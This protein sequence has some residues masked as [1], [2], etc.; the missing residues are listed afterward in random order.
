MEPDGQRYEDVGG[1]TRDL[2]IDIAREWRGGRVLLVAHSA[3]RWALAHL[4][5][6]VP[7]E[8]QVDAPFAWRTGWHFTLPSDWGGR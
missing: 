2:L 4:L 6:G 7:R 3:N 1:Q 8:A 5:D